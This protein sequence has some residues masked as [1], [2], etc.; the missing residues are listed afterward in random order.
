MMKIKQ[1]LREELKKAQ[2]EEAKKQ[3][4][5][6]KEK[7]REEIGDLKRMIREAAKKEKNK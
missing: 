2:Q 5:I 4:E 1:E 3:E 6:K 7:E